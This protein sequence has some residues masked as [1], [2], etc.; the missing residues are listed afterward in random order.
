MLNLS[1]GMIRSE[2]NPGNDGLE[3]GELKGSNIRYSQAID[4]QFSIA[5]CSEH[6]NFQFVYC[7]N[8]GITRI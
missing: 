3:L 2:F 6:Q 1:G 5:S 7:F 8:T 4:V